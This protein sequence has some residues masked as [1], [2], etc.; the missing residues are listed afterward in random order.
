[1][2]FPPSAIICN[3]RKNTRPYLSPAVPADNRRRFFIT[4]GA[5]IHEEKK[6]ADRQKASAT[7]TVRLDVPS[8]AELPKDR[9]KEQMKLYRLRIVPLGEAR[10]HGSGCHFIR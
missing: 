10:K 6:G 2:G 8:R 1:M 9:G 5:G 3:Q 7:D 4:A